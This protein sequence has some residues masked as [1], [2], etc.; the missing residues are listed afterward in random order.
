MD[1]GREA[2]MGRVAHLEGRGLECLPVGSGADKRGRVLEF[3]SKETGI[4]KEEMGRKR[5]TYSRC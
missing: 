5:K 2:V 3:V 1:A 4:A